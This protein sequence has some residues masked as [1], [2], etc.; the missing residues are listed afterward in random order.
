MTF[1]SSAL[2]AA[3][4]FVAVLGVFG[5]VSA[6]AFARSSTKVAVVPGYTA[7]VYPGFF[8][9]P[10]FPA[11]ALPG[12][13]FTAVSSS[14]LT[15]SKLRGFDTVM[16]YGLRWNTLSSDAQQ[17]IND[18]AK[19]GKVIIWDSDATGPQDYSTF[20]HAF[21]TR[22]SGEYGSKAG[23]LVTYPGNGNPL[24]SSNPSS[25]LYLDPSALVAS[26]HLVGHM[27]VMNAGAPE[28]APGVIAHNPSI[29]DGGWVLAWGYGSTGDH[30]G[31]V[32]YSGLDADA[33]NDA[34]KP[35]YAIKELQ[36]ELAASFSATADTTCS[37]NCAAPPVA[38][39]GSGGSGGG[40]GTGGS[41]GGTGGGGGGGTGTFAQCS[42]ATPAPKTWVHSTV[43][44][45][46]KTS[47]ATGLKV[48]ALDPTGHQLV[49]GKATKKVGRY[50]LDVNTRRLKSNKRSR[51][52]VVVEV[53][54]K[55]A[56]SLAVLLK[57]DNTAPRI[58]IASARR[59][60][61]EV[62][63]GFRVSEGVTA[64]IVSGT[65]VRRVR[66]AAGK[67]VHIMIPAGATSVRITARDRAGNTTTRRLTIKRR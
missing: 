48:R 55:R 23:A 43:S 4:A 19:T 59:A 57:V 2:R 41:G 28:W 51:V 37:P 67:A 8:G 49:L 14:N 15:A 1:K 36:I 66:A 40:G 64:T 56:C 17:A 42:L 34:A 7:P 39:S 46:V 10:V 3:V 12:Y 25:S 50:A 53:G 47:V 9:I 44:L 61:T 30:S 26:T 65:H 38:G 60:L 20:V 13:Q 18:F 32:I 29:P 24:A 62:N 52:L 58:S 31:M 45:I 21:S 11:N 22:A 5:A 33:F 54:A 27:S 16:I 35:N 63:V 6:N